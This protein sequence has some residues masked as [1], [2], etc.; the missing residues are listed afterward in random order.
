MPGVELVVPLQRCAADYSPDPTQQPLELLMFN[1][2]Q[3]CCAAR[4]VAANSSFP[5]E[6]GPRVETDVICEEDNY[7]NQKQII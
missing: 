7:T 2:Y 1:K 4:L 3:L 6:F 5:L